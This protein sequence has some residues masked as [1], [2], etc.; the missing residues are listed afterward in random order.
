MADIIDELIRKRG[1]ASRIF[2]NREVL[3]PDYIPDTLPHRENEIR[4]LAEHLLVSAQ[5][6]RPSNV[7]I[8]GLTG[9]GKTVVVKYVVSKLKEKASSLNKRLDYAYVNTRKLDTT[10]RVIASIAQSIG[11]RVPHTGLAISEVYRRYINALDS[12]GGLHIIVLDEVDYYVKREGDDL[13]YKLVRANEE[14]SKAKIVLI[15]ITND[16]NFVENLDPRVRSSMGEIEMVFPPY[17]AEQLF[18]ILKQRA[19]LAFNQ[20]VIEDGVISYC[21]ALA[22][23]EHGD[24]RRALD[25]LR[26]SGE[27]AEREGAERVTIEY[28]KKATLEI[29]EGRI[30]QSVVTLPLHQKLVLKKIVELVEAK[31]STTTG[32]VYTAYSNIMRNL[33]YEPLSLRRISEIISQL[34]MMGLIISE[35]VNRGKYGITRII[36]IRKDMLPVIKDALKDVEA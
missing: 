30:Y 20:G 8:Y 15:G 33:K 16:V 35:V 34:D 1:F 9:T 29:E 23:R 12:W 13:I 14:L 7:L 24:A 2:R 21:S 31:E 11:L 18:T 36:K 17:N 3:H 25:L 10:Y 28:V 19:E 32:E 4:R 27:I 26:V 5:G 6:M 22:A